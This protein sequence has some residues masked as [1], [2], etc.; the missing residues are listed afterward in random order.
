MAFTFK[1]NEISQ[2]NP[3]T[4]FFNPRGKITGFS[5]AAWGNLPASLI[6]NFW[7]PKGSYYEITVSFRSKQ[8]ICSQKDLPETL[9]DRVTFFFCTFFY[10][11]N[12]FGLRSY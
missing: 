4:L 3:I 12:F 8:V 7:I 5:V 2:A 6:G 11:S 1:N 9:G 10:N